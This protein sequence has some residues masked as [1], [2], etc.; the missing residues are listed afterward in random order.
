[1]GPDQDVPDCNRRDDPAPAPRVLVAS[2]A[3]KL[4]QSSCKAD[5]GI[6]AVLHISSVAVCAACLRTLLSWHTRVWPLAIHSRWTGNHPR[7]LRR[8]G[9]V[10][11][12]RPAA[13]D[14]IG[15]GVRLLQT[16][17][18]RVGPPASAHPRSGPPWL[19]LDGTFDT[20]AIATPAHFYHPTLTSP[21]HAYYIH[22]YPPPLA[23]CV[24]QHR[25]PGAATRSLTPRHL[26][27]RHPPPPV[28]LR[29]CSSPPCATSTSTSTSR[30]PASVQDNVG[31]GK[32][33]ACGLWLV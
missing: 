6:I 19:L 29:D 20:S 13:S 2:C 8:S 31:L 27:C 7:T 12:K 3:L 11:A 23:Q 9:V 17:A 1:M 18:G 10:A 16:P 21:P 25:A 33:Q 4:I 22:A 14:S 32:W 24:R 26:T 15:A 30:N 5:A 28:G